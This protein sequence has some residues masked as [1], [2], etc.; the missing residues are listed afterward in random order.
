MCVFFCHLSPCHSWCRTVL[1]DVRVSCYCLTYRVDHLPAWCRTVLPDV[2]V[3]CYCLTDRAS[4]LP[5]RCRTVLPDCTSQL[6][7]P[8]LRAGHLPAW[9]QLLY[10]FGILVTW[11]MLCLSCLFIFCCWFF[12]WVVMAQWHFGRP[13]DWPTYRP[14]NRTTNWPNKPTC[15]HAYRLG[16]TRLLVLF[17]VA[18]MKNE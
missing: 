6:L 7:L 17:I 5:A 16:T 3:S 4:H 12:D 9:P 11:D 10:I 14:S 18:Q 8:D 13:T 2:R 15:L 1:P